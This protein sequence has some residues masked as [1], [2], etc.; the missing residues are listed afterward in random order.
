M[1]PTRVREPMERA[2]TAVNVETVETVVSEA[3]ADLAAKA[4]AEIAFRG[5]AYATSV[6]TRWI[7][8][9]TRMW[10]VCAST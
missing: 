9:I 5:V 2:G 3:D 10:S 1:G 6:S 4:R 8:W 7:S